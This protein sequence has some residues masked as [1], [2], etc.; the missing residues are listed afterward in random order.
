LDFSSAPDTGSDVRFAVSLVVLLTS[1][2]AIADDEKDGGVEFSVKPLLCIVDQRTPGCD[3]SFLVRW[4]SNSTGY[5]CVFNSQ[6][7]NPLNCW[8]EQRAGE[9]RDE[10]S[11]E[12]DLQFWINES[13][14][15]ALES[16]TVEVLRMDSDDRRRRRRSRHVWDI[17]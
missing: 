3:M 9:L 13:G 2:I 5:Y 1:V 4:S 8:S 12:E 6:E 11:V 7:E 15:V 14:G 10:R 16:I 17:L